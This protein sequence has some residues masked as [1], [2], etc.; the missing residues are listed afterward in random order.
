MGS[1]GHTVL[2]KD[3]I[4]PQLSQVKSY[5]SNTTGVVT[6]EI[7]NKFHEAWRDT[8]V[9]EI[10]DF[11]MKEEILKVVEN[12]TT[13]DPK[14]PV[15]EIPE[16]QKVLGTTKVCWGCFSGICRTRQYI[17]QPI[18]HKKAINRFCP[19]K[20]TLLGDK[21]LKRILKT[22]GWKNGYVLV[23]NPKGSFPNFNKG[24]RPQRRPNQGRPAF[25][26][27]SASVIQKIADPEPSETIVRAN[28]TGL[29]DDEAFGPAFLYEQPEL[30]VEKRLIPTNT[31]Y[32]RYNQTP[33]E[34]F[35]REDVNDIEDYPQNNICYECGK[36]LKWE[37]MFQDC[38]VSN[39]DIN[40]ID[41]EIANT[42]EDENYS[43][44]G[45]EEKEWLEQKLNEIADE[46][47]TV[48]ETTSIDK[49]DLIESVQELDGNIITLAKKFNTVKEKV[50]EEIQVHIDRIK[51]SEED[52]VT[53]FVQVKTEMEGAFQQQHATISNQNEEVQKAK[54]ATDQI[55]RN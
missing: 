3:K 23:E 9:N 29:S 28:F 48:K 13:E 54:I 10:E 50:Y 2:Y 11:T 18:L 44:Y 34:E 40:E 32:K 31:N 39:L 55:I 37:N 33:K 20:K 38:G 24:Q 35:Y 14:K 30:F 1:K 7:K 53:A 25:N 41:E 22:K 17:G 16:V 8:K 52:S 43:T 21:D 46:L 4:L 36:Q 19:N 42:W 47:K 15:I 45:P 12:M 26:N 49:Q 27:N 6:D 5:R 51:S